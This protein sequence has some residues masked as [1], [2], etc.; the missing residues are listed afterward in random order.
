[1]P[2][3]PRDGAGID[4]GASRLFGLSVV[5]AAGALVAIGVALVDGTNAVRVGPREPVGH[6]RVLNESF[7]YPRANVAA[8][9]VL[10]LAGLGLL[11][12]LRLT[13]SADGRGAGAAA[14]LARCRRPA[15]P[16]LRRRDPRRR[17]RTA[18]PS[19]PA[20]CARRSSCRRGRFASSA[21]TSSRRC[22][23]TR[24]TIAAA[25]THCASRS[26]GCSATR[27]SS[28]RS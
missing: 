3:S 27:S 18:A 2:S 26:R 24:S 9:V 5:L 4:A 12:L 20:C 8:I 28:C 1:M 13:W 6:F 10:V 25:A 16:P 21:T 11:V 7:T 15:P 14:L 19:A 23:P 22:W 17:R